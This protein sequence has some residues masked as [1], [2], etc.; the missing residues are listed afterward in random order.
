MP[1][2]VQKYGGTSV[3][4][5]ERIF[6]V[7]WKIK[8]AVEAG[9]QCV[10]VVSAMGHETDRLVELAHEISPEPSAREM[11]MLLSTGEQVSIALVTMAL[12]ALDVPAR[13]LTGWQAGIITEQSHGKACVEKVDVST[14]QH[15]LNE[16][17]VV[18]VAGFQGVTH[19]QEITTLGRGGSDT[20]A[21]TLAAALQ[22]DAC[23]IYTDVTGVY[24]ADPRVVPFSRKMDEITY[25]EMLELANLGA[26][27]L[28]PR[29]VECAMM[30]RVPLVVR[31]SFVDQPG[32]WVK[33]DTQMENRLQVRGLAHDLGVA[34]VKVMGLPNYHSTLASLFDLLATEKI[35]V[36]MISQ[37]EQ[38][39]EWMS[40]SFSIDEVDLLHAIQVL[41]CAKESL[42]YQEL[43]SEQG[44]AKVSI[45]GVG[46]MTHPGVAAHM[47][48]C[49]SDAQ[50]PV[51][52]VTTSEIKISCLVSAELASRAVQELHASFGLNVKEEAH[53]GV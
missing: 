46:M 5:A 49:L 29:S 7:A 26:G 23:E 30:H 17:E 10:I 28:H 13:S 11:D 34:R 3:G 44:L 51:K 47:F 53:I 37:S 8:R 38:H 48:R 9:D 43:I 45:V 50:I 16:G 36:D 14:I 4:T 24:T 31:S 15:Y 27:V 19:D 20:T 22:A 12:H 6:R 1:L 39:S 33:E 52:M 32:T 2:I 18:V 42:G 35:N 21:V 25:E 40:V 41:E